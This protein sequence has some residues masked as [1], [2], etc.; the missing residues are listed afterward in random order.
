MCC[1]LAGGVCGMKVSDDSESHSDTHI[2][3]TDK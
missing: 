1:S 3:T 2:A